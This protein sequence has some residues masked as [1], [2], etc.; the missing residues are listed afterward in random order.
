MASRSRVRIV[1][2]IFANVELTYSGSSFSDREIEA[3]RHRFR[4]GV[5]PQPALILLVAFDCGRGNTAVLERQYLPVAKNECNTVDSWYDD[6]RTCID[7][8]TLYLDK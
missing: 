7:T 3:L 6:E 5:L 4:L 1:I 2:A 8:A